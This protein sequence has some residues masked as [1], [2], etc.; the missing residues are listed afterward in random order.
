MPPRTA[1]S[2]PIARAHQRLAGGYGVARDRRADE[3]LRPRQCHRVV[4]QPQLRHNLNV[5]PCPSEDVVM[6]FL[7]AREGYCDMFASAMAV[8]CR[9][10]NIPARR[11]RLYQRLFD[12]A[13]QTHGARGGCARL[14]RSLPRLWVGELRSTPAASDTML[15]AVDGAVSISPATPEAVVL[16]PGADF[17]DRPGP[18]RRTWHGS[19][20]R[21]VAAGAAVIRVLDHSRRSGAACLPHRLSPPAPAWPAARI[22]PRMSIWRQSPRACRKRLPNLKR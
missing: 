6:H 8:M 5:P 4:S 2:L 11:Q 15:D 3:Q 9:L 13:T 21:P 1:R 22:R 12:P 17:A 7:T 20:C 18:S 10:A 16:F 19:P 14:G